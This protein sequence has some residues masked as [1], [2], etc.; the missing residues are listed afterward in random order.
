[1]YCNYCEQYNGNNV[2]WNT[3]SANS[4]VVVNARVNSVVN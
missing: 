3:F 2:R 4:I 1:M